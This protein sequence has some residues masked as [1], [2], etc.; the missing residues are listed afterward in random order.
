MSSTKLD[1]AFADKLLGC[2]ERAPSAIQKLAQAT[3]STRDNVLNVLAELQLLGVPIEQADGVFTFKAGTAHLNDPSDEKASKKLS[4]KTSE[5]ISKKSRTLEY[6]KTHVLRPNIIESSHTWLVNFLS[7]Q[8]VPDYAHKQA[9]FA[10]KKEWSVADTFA[11]IPE[12]QT[13]G[14]GRRGRTWCS[15]YAQGVLCSVA[16]F[17]PLPPQR[18][19]GLSLALG[20]DIASRLNDAL[21]KVEKVQLKWPNDII[22]LNAN[23]YEKIGGVLVEFVSSNSPSGCWVVVGVG[24][25]VGS[26]PECSALKTS[27]NNLHNTPASIDGVSRQAALNLLL[28]AVCYVLQD[29]PNKGFEHWRTAWQNLHAFHKKNVLIEQACGTLQ[30]KCDGVDERGALLLSTA[31]GQQVLYSGDVSLRPVHK[32][33]H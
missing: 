11:V 7:G 5:K 29:Y 21:S 10:P 13:Q 17:L 16:K 20:A 6:K 31:S 27:Q 25:N 3:H 30:G 28:E 19:T 8:C 26:A 14:V 32:K 15:G 9:L 12:F 24:V 33:Q 18:L 23:S 2:I 22:R 1:I 4:G